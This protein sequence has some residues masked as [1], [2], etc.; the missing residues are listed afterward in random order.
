L[1]NQIIKQKDDKKTSQEPK[2]FIE[3]PSVAVQ[4]ERQNRSVDGI[5]IQMTAVAREL[6]YLLV[7]I[8]REC[9]NKILHEYEPEK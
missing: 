2:I 7:G 9:K 4:A 5:E 6:Q 3:S 1:Y 8:Y